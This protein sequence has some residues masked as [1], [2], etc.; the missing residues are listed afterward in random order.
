[1][2]LAKV[3]HVAGI[4]HVRRKCNA[5]R[6][7]PNDFAEPSRDDRAQPVGANDDSRAIRF[8]FPA[9][10]VPRNHATH[11]GALVNEILDSD[12]FPHFGARSLGGISQD[13]IE[14]CSGEGVA[15]GLEP[16][17]DAGAAGRDHFHPRQ[18]CRSRSGDRI[19]DFR[20]KALEHA[21]RLRRRTRPPARASSR[22]VAEPAGPAPTTIAS[23]RVTRA[24][25]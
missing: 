3:V 6:R 4:S 18:A 22:A 1:M 5:I 17:Y 10:R 14:R 7:R 8:P 16:A 23:Q 12:A 21:R 25:P 19:Q 15:E 20:A 9:S 13:G 11:R 24:W 2:H